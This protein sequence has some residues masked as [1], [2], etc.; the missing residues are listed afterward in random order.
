MT[1][2]AQAFVPTIEASSYGERIS[3][4]LGK[5]YPTEWS[6][7]AGR[8]AMPD[9]VCEMH[10]WPDGLRLDA[11]AEDDGALVRIEKLV[12]ATIEG[13]KRDVKSPVDWYRRPSA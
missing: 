5:Q 1:L 6:A 11:F 7:E 10:S 8:V 13:I 3:Q 4:V 12:S 2:H 9:A